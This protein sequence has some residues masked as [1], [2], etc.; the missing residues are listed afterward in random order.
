M[1]F[2]RNHYISD[3]LTLSTACNLCNFSEGDEFHY[4]LACPKL[5]DVRSEFIS[6]EYSDRPSLITFKMLMQTNDEATLLKLSK[7]L[8]HI[9]KVLWFLF[10]T[11]LFV[12]FYYY[13]LC[14]SVWFAIPCVYYLYILFFFKLMF[15]FIIMLLLYICTFGEKLESLCLCIMFIVVQSI[16]WRGPN[17]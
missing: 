9:L 16:P 2:P 17:K 15:W 4:I 11:C 7:F 13:M 3:R 1:P 14:S 6:P 5:E 8:K 10:N 12:Y